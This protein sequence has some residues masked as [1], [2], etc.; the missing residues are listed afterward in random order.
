[1][2]FNPQVGNSRFENDQNLQRH[3]QM[4][5]G[6]QSTVD[7]NRSLLAMQQ[8]LTENELR[9]L[10]RQAL[11]PRAGMAQPHAEFNP[12]AQQSGMIGNP[13]GMSHIFQGINKAVRGIQD[14]TQ[15]EVGRL[16]RAER[17]QQMA[18]LEKNHQ[19]FENF[20]KMLRGTVQPGT[21]GSNYNF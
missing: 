2:T 12:Y 4:L 20:N 21:A 17:E 11:D 10:G 9:Y 5:G 15:L 7:S 14:G 19:R 6:L 13:Q 3:V 16:M 1:M 18:D 8:S